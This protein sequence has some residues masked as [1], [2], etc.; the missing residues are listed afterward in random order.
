[1]FNGLSGL[2]S[3]FVDLYGLKQHVHYNPG[4]GIRVTPLKSVHYGP[5]TIA[6]IVTTGGCA[7]ICGFLTIIYTIKKHLV[8]RRHNRTLGDK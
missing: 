6:T 1:M 2:I 7:A 3:T 5:T 8:K 4:T